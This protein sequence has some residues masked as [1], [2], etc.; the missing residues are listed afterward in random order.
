MP[1]E[2]RVLKFVRDPVHDIIRIQVRDRFILELLDTVP[3]QRLRRIRQL[4]LTSLVYPGAE[5]SR[6]THSLGVFCLAGRVMAQLSDEAGIDLFD[7]GRREAV[8]AAALLHDVGHG[9]FSHVFERVARNIAGSSAVSHETWT[10][11]VIMETKIHSI[12][13]NVADDLPDRVCE[14]LDH[15]YRPH[16]VTAI[17]SSQLDVD[18]F[19]YLLRDAR[20]TGTHY[21]DFDLGW[22]LRTL[23]VRDVP[24][25]SAGSDGTPASLTTIVVDGQRGL[26]VLEAHLIGRHYMYRHVY[27]H[28]T[29]RAAEQ[30]LRA[31]LQR[32][33]DLVRKGDSHLGNDAFRRMVTEQNLDVAEYLELN[34]SAVMAW[35]EDW[36]R[37]TSDTLLRDLAE[38]LVDRRLMKA[39]IAPS[40]KETTRPRFSEN[41]A[42][43]RDL[44]EQ[45]GYD[46]EHYML[47]DQV[48]DVAYKGYLYNLERGGRADEEEIW[49]IDRDRVPRR[50]SSYSGV[51]TRASEAL[52]FDED[53]WFVPD[54][55]AKAAHNELKW[56]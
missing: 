29:I 13:A 40:K 12:L 36:S 15:T 56:K 51:L 46:P 19:D 4:G 23:A 11:R 6:F 54:E 33:A 3:M 49:F 41:R 25:A 7:Q 21:G 24:A 50:L 8:L 39:V 27:Y 9:P 47:E 45:H 5:H 20:M 31:I 42:R 16:Y 52:Q 38:R 18:R 14:I 34:D 55:V 48:E 28:K 17:I 26:S 37:T 2:S 22:M 32:A 30:M 1:D 10:K 44:V 53:R 35:L 43:L